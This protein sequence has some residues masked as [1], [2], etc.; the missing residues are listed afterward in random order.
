MN[1]NLDISKQSFN[2]IKRTY[3]PNLSTDYILRFSFVYQKH[4]IRQLRFLNF[5]FKL[6]KIKEYYLNVHF[7][8]GSSSRILINYD[9]V[10]NI[11]KSVFLANKFLNNYHTLKSR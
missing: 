4:W 2:T 1:N 11:E 5:I 7:S 6:F 9:E 10:K 8:D 3:L